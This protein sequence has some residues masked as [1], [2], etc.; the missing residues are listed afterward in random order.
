MRKLLFLLTTV[1]CVLLCSFA[2][3]ETVT[4]DSIYATV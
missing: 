3:A 4:L 2:C 1:L